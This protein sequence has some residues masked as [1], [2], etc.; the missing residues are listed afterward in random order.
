MT[1][2]IIFLLAYLAYLAVGVSPPVNAKAA[3]QL[4]ICTIA[5]V[6]ILLMLY[7]A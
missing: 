3:A 2:V 5:F 4:V 7:R 6:L 1:P